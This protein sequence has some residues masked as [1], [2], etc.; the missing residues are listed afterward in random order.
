MFLPS[1]SSGCLRPQA[2]PGHVALQALRD[3]Q[4]LR[5]PVGLCAGGYRAPIRMNINLVNMIAFRTVNARKVG[6]GRINN[7]Y[8]AQRI[9]QP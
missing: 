6:A 7:E 2:A 5:I 9:P 3:F 4:P 1:R 8:C